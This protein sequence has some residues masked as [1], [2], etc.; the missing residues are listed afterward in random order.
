M[1]HTRLKAGQAVV[2][3]GAGPVEK[4]TL[5]PTAIGEKSKDFDMLI[6]EIEKYLTINNDLMF[7][8]GPKVKKK[9]AMT[10][11]LGMPQ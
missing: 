2:K 1:D 11:F 6:I 7:S 3:K 9:I 5:S 8:E 10:E 4:N